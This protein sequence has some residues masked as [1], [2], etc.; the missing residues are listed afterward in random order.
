M[1]NWMRELVW[2]AITTTSTVPLVREFGEKREVHY[3]PTTCGCPVLGCHRLDRFGRTDRFISVLDGYQ[4]AASLVDMLRAPWDNSHRREFPWSDP[5][6]RSIRMSS[7][8]VL[9]GL[10]VATIS[11]VKQG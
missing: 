2:G 10:A 5:M 7:L 8:V 6:S 4:L 3:A 9:L 1:V 11:A